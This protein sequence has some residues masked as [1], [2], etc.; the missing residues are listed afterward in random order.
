MKTQQTMESTK[1][2]ITSAIN[3]RR[4]EWL[5]WHRPNMSVEEFRWMMLG[6]LQEIMAQRGV[7]KDY[8]IDEYNKPILNNMYLYI[9]GSDR[10]KWDLNKGV[11]LGGKIGTGKTLLMQAFTKALSEISGYHIEMV[12]ARMLSNLIV[13]NGIEYY[14][15]RPLFIDELGREN[16]EE[17]YYGRIIRPV[18]EL[19]SY[20][21]EY[22]ARIFFTSNFK[23][24][25]LGKGYDENGKKIGYGQYIYSRMKEMCSFDVLEGEDRRG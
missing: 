4:S 5:L 6:Y 10:C 9:I 17:N 16:L 15:K 24:E 21:Y 14:M 20:R 12:P 22:G 8:V 19:I 18:E 11:Y 1:D 3:N 25:R 13:K 7:I 23:P 2:T